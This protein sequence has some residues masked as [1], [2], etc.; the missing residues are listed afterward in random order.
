[1]RYWISALSLIAAIAAI[2][3]TIAKA[4]IHSETEEG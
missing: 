1:L 2:E 3:K 4:A